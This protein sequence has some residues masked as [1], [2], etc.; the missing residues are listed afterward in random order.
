MAISGRGRSLSET[1]ALPPKPDIESP[2]GP[3][4]LMTH[5]GHRGQLR[6]MAENDLI[7]SIRITIPIIEAIE[8]QLV[9]NPNH[10]KPDGK[11]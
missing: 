5:S 10:S 8:S 4:P 2:R 3:R 9:H 6:Q 11:L 1:S 7:Q